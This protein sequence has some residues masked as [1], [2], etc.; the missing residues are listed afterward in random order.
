MKIHR[1]VTL[2][3]ALVM[4]AALMVSSASAA[5]ANQWNDHPSPGNGAPWA[6][7]PKGKA[8]KDSGP[9]SYPGN[10][11]PWAQPPKGK[12]EKDSGPT[13]YPGNGA[14]WA[15]PPKGKAEKDSGPTSYPGNGA[16]W[17]NSKRS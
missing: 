4:L 9:T 7:P 16:P 6:Q 3:L 12:A 5:D 8:E 11:A 10:G 1:S 15:Q 17:A 14:P 2:A 13:S